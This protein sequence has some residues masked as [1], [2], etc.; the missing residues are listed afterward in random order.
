MIV[1][2]REVDVGGQ[3]SYSKYFSGLVPN[4]LYLWAEILKKLRLKGLQREMI[5]GKGG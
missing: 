2:A 5:V 3:R 4:M 1:G